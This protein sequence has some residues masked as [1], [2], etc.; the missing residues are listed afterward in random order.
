DNHHQDCGTAIAVGIYLTSMNRKNIFQRGFTLLELLVVISIIGILVG[1]GAVS[2]TTAQKK[3]RDSRRLGDMRAM[4]AVYEQYYSNPTN[5]YQYPVDCSDASITSYAP[6]GWPDD[7]KNAAP[8][9]YSTNCSASGYC[10]CAALEGGTGNGGSS[11]DATCSGLNS[12]TTFFCVKNQ[13]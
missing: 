7:P 9:V 4:Q 5:S 1:L 2:Y 10:F 8:Y 11:A 12:G 3:A 13:Q 6:A